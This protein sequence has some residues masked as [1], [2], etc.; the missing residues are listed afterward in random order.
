MIVKAQTSDIKII[1]DITT[2][3]ITHIYPQ[4]YPKGA[5]EFFLEHHNEGNI[6]KDIEQGIVY[7]CKDEHANSIGTVTV[8]KNEICRLFVLPEY[9]GM[10]YGRELLNYAEDLIMKAYGQVVID[11][12]L[13]AKSIYLKRGYVAT[14]F[15]SIKTSNGDYL[16]YDVMTKERV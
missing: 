9:Q 13:P 12:S 14:E 4:Y 16:C 7:L 1:K 10:G 8:K 5:V 6:A 11:A 15:H 3:T 2:N